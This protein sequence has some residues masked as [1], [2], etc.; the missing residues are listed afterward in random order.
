MRKG[1]AFE[2]LIKIIL[3]LAV[4]L[5][6]VGLLVPF[7]NYFL[8][9]DFKCRISVSLVDSDLMKKLSCESKDITLTP[10]QYEDSEEMKKII[11]EEMQACWSLFGKGSRNNILDIFFGN[12]ANIEWENRA[13]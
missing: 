3:I 11:A 10:K 4:V 7:M 1:M 6:V 9:E 8:N 5:L 2:Q 13:F 12:I